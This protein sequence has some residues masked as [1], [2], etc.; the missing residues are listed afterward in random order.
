MIIKFDL[1]L[2]QTLQIYNVYFYQRSIGRK[3]VNISI[4]N[5]N[6]ERLSRNVEKYLY[7][8]TIQSAKEKCMVR[9]WDNMVFKELYVSKIRSFD[10]NICKTSY[11]QNY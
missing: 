11:I 8:A 6:N 1:K 2:I 9:K 3:H 4:M 10:S 7:N 5:Y